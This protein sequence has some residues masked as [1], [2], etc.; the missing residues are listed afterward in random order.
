M[1]DHRTAAL[2]IAHSSGSMTALL[3]ALKLRD[4]YTDGHCDRVGQL[5]GMLCR[6]LGL[7]PL[8]VQQ[9]ELAARF[10]DIGKIG[11]PDAVLLSPHRHDDAEQAIMREHPI[12]GETIFLATGREDA[13]QVARLIRAHHEAFDGSG[14]PDGLRGEHIPLGARVLTIVD[15]YDA[16]TSDR[17]YR[18]AMPLSKAMRILEDAE[19]GL[20][21]PYVLR[22]FQ[23]MLHRAPMLR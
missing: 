2:D 18:Q 1:S 4:A 3:T 8:E 16:M 13:A 23:A 20:L 12:H 9:M 5:C 10:H 6:F 22:N 17:P 19:G 7:P 14:Y 15:A 21:D 11:T